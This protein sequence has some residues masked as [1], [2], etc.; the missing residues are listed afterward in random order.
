MTLEDRNAAALRHRLERGNLTGE[1]S[2]RELL[3]LP[4]YSGFVTVAVGD[5]VRFSMLLCDRDDGVALRCF[6]NGAYEPATSRLMLCLSRQS[7][8]IIDVGA[9]TGYYT[10]LCKS[11]FPGCRVSAIEASAMNAS[12]LA[13]N[14]RAN[15]ASQVSI[16]NAA[17][18]DRAGQAVFSNTSVYG[19]HSSGGHLIDDTDQGQPISLVTLDGL[20][21][22]GGGVV[23][24]IKCDV[25]GHES[26]VLGGAREL[27]ARDRPN[28]VLE[29][30]TSIEPEDIRLRNLGY[31][32]FWIDE[33]NMELWSITRPNGTPAGGNGRNYFAT[34][35]DDAE[36]AAAVGHTLSLRS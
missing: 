22:R 26:A 3:E 10:L 6:W 16:V 23:D 13:V 17:A 33:A 30:M 4:A 9:H 7:T 32:F 27:I 35:M 28:L 2:L 20:V 25:E 18:S 31:R 29:C 34:V 1:A 12:R 5:D 21:G 11:A 15:G 14:I 8:W 19:Y 24:L 36:I